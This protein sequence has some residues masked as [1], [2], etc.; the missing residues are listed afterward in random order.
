MALPSIRQRMTAVATGD[1]HLWQPPQPRRA[2]TVVLLRSGEAG[3]E[4]FLM[5]RAASMKA[6]PGMFVF[7]GG[8][9][10]T[11]DGDPE[12]S[13][14]LR[15][16][17]LRELAEETGLLLAELDRLEGFARWVTPEVLPHRHDTEFFA[18]TVRGGEDPGMVGGESEHADW[19]TPQQ[20]LVNPGI[21]LLPP[22]SA[23]LHLLSDVADTQSALRK[24]RRLPVRPLMPAPLLQGTGF[25]WQVIDAETRQTVELSRFGLPHDWRPALG[26]G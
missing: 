18:V 24:L 14:T 17:A 3:V 13:A 8:G 12:D 25:G 9:V 2:A 23:V 21:A 22:T 4:V 16:A 20:A 7:P 19:Y 6:A 11:A 10:D 15:R 5:K 1:L 26:G